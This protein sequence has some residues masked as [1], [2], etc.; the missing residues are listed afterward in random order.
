[1]RALQLTGA[2]LLRTS[3]EALGTA[4]VLLVLDRTGHVAAAGL[5]V[6]AA[7]F[8]Q[9]IAGPIIGDLLDRVRRPQ[10]YTA[11]LATGYA[12]AMALLLTVAGRAPL[13]VS[14]AMGVVVGTC[15][16]I[17]V[18]LSSV[19]PRVVPPSGLPRAYA[20]EAASYNLASVAGPGIVALLAAVDG[21]T[22]A[23][24]AV[25]AIGLLGAAAMLSLRLP[26]GPVPARPDWTAPARG[27]ITLFAGRTLRAVTVATTL[28]FAAFGGVPVVT[29][30]LAEHVGSRSTAG[31]WLISAFAIGALSG[32]LLSAR[33]SHKKPVRT[34]VTHLVGVG[35]L[36]G[37]AA[38]AGGLGVAAGCFA[39]AGFFDGP[40]FAAVLAV[41]Q[42]E[43]PADSLGR[44][45]TTAGSLKI[46]AGALGAAL[47]AALAGPLGAVG[48]LLAMAACQLLAALA[49]VSLLRPW[50]KR[51]GLSALDSLS[52]MR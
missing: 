12:V 44:V 41:R 25:V 4:L 27:L 2:T 38:C 1:M 16:P 19:I 50:R 20:F 29:V 10:V 47:T 9:V 3:D 37:A 5:I 43:A 45:N 32:S 11:C 35:V 30:L 31:G 49:A 34:V 52:S 26:G 39:V 14:M 7:M 42:R 33:R 24:V 8:P 40:M 21:A 22:T 17:A 28:A 23:S 51:A 18:A 36:L 13:A 46:G 6:G 48:L 15:A